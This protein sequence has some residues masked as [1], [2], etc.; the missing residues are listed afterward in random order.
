LMQWPL[1]SPAAVRN[2]R[3][4][5]LLRSSLASEQNPL[6]DGPTV[7]GAGDSIRITRGIHWL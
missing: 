4:S 5:R 2:P 3:T 1:D 6:P 7:L